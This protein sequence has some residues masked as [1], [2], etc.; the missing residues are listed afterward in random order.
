MWQIHYGLHGLPPSVQLSFSEAKQ[1]LGRRLFPLFLYLLHA[2]SAMQHEAC[3]LSNLCQSLQAN[4]KCTVH[5]A[6]A[7]GWSSKT[8]PTICFG[9]H[10]DY[11]AVI[12]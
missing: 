2:L 8:G 7:T 6:S 11:A 3:D 9:G 4:D 5:L 12:F 10:A 1:A